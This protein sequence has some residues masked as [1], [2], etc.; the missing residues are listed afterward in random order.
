MQS[1]KK[2]L[3]E[4]VYSFSTEDHY[5]EYDEDDTHFSRPT[6][7]PYSASTTNLTDNID[8]ENND[9]HNIQ[10]EDNIPD[11]TEVAD[12]VS[13]VLLAWKHID[14]WTD[15][16]NPDLNASLGDPC[17]LNDINDVEKDLDISFP[18]CVRASMRTHDGQEDL[19][20]YTGV[21]G[22][23]YGLQLMPIDDVVNMTNAWRNVAVNIKKSDEKKLQQQQQQQSLSSDDAFSTTSPNSSS[24]APSSAN[25]NHFKMNEIPRQGS[26]P[27]NT[28]QPV[29]AHPAWI[30][31]VTDNAGNH[32]GIDLA[33][34]PEGTYGQVLL[35]GREFDTKF[36]VAPNWGDFLLSFANDLIQGNWYFVG[37]DDDFFSGEGDLVYR[38]KVHGSNI[39]QDYMEVLKKRSFLQWKSTKK[40]APVPQPT[41]DAGANNKLE[42]D[43][44][45]DNATSNKNVRKDGKV[46]QNETLVQ[47]ETPRDF[48]DDLEDEQEGKTSVKDVIDHEDEKEVKTNVKDVVDDIVDENEVK[49][50]K[51]EPLTPQN[52]NHTPIPEKKE[53]KDEVGEKLDKEDDLTDKHEIV[54]E[55]EELDNKE[56]S[57]SKQEK[58]DHKEPLEEDAKKSTDLKDVNQTEENKEDSA[59]KKPDTETPGQEKK[60]EFENIEL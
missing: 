12:G 16:H 43:T 50:I 58:N 20:S 28:V 31:L 21:S 40:S 1:F 6:S 34:G 24:A 11:N 60:D 3:R 47:V 45:V 48:A 33:P 55:K 52:A 26:I 10:L 29:Y 8:L 32:I 57:V 22:L 18:P 4:L 42:T 15:E 44:P 51:E 39:I 38:D 46:L 7:K 25:T 30:P 36:V 17:T 27:P 13:E 2:K 23:I 54:N 49:N 53:V 35:F 9:F 19:E 56:S 59:T 41:T 5:A 37:E 14:K